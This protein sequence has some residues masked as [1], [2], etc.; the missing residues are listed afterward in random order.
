MHNKRGRS[1][2]AGSRSAARVFFTAL[3]AVCSSAFAQLPDFLQVGWRLTWEAGDSQISGSRLVPDPSGPLERD[4][5]RYRLEGTRGGGGIGLI[6]LDM[7]AS[8]QDGLLADLRF[9]LNLDV[10]T[11]ALRA[12]GNDVVIGGPGGLGEYWVPP[13]N[14]AALTPGFDG[15]TRISRSTVAFGGQTLNVVTIATPGQGSYSSQ[16]YDLGSG[17]MLFSGTMHSSQGTSITDPNGQITNLAGSVAYSHKSFLG[18]RQLSVP[19]AFEPPPQWA[20][21][22]RAHFYQGESRAEFNSPTG[23]PPLGGQGIQITQVFD[24]QVGGAI[25]ARQIVQAATT[26]GLPP[27]ESTSQ[28]AFSSLL[29]DNLW[30]PP[31]AFGNLQPQQVLDQDP[32]SRQTTFYAGVSGNYGVIVVQGSSDYLENYYDLNS[33]LL[34]FSRYRVQAASVGTQVTETQWVGQQ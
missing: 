18:V 22:G 4:G 1:W 13:A 29:L 7:V 9:F 19:W 33:G 21:P 15:R 31:R 30:F 12:S 23:L 8:G 32:F 2:R 14:L 34:M 28:R 10:N 20:T 16:T 25:L 27:S 24:R 5:Q 3:L 11:G 17:L 6:Q 26:A